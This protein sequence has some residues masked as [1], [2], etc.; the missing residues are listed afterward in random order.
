VEQVNCGFVERLKEA[1]MK[2]GLGSAVSTIGVQASPLAKHLGVSVQTIRKYLTG[3]ASPDLGRI[4]SISEFL[5]VSPGWLAFGLQELIVNTPQKSFEIK[6]IFIQEIFHGLFKNV[7]DI[8]LEDDLLESIYGF[9]F[10][11]INDIAQLESTDEMKLRL[12]KT[13]IASAS[14]MEKLK[15]KKTSITT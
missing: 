9:L 7:L 14:I 6:K 4:I 12:I 11:I 5:Q 1:L 3:C 10:G 13:S 2:R 15:W 8:Q